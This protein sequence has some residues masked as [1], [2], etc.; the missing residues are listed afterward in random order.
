MNITGMPVQIQLFN[1]MEI[2]IVGLPNVGKSTLFNALT[3]AS[4]PA[5]NFPFTTIEPNVGIAAIEDER[6]FVVAKEYKSRKSTPAGIRFTDIA[7]LV[8]G[9]SAGEG[10]GNKFL[11]HIRAVDALAHVIRAFSDDN[12]ANVMGAV[13]PLACAKTIETE[14]LV[15]DLQQ[16]Q[17]ARE[18]TLKMAKAGDARLKE[19]ARKLEPIIEG[20]GKG[21]AVRSQKADIDVVR[22]VQ[23]LTAKPVMYVV[24][25]DEKGLPDEVLRPL[26]VS[27]RSEEAPIVTLCAKLEEE[28]QELPAEER[29]SYYE[30]AGIDV[31]GLV[32]LASA[33]KQ[34]LN[35]ICFYTANEQ[36]ARAWLIPQGTKAPQ[37]AGRIHSDMETGFIRAEVYNVEDLKQYGSSKILQ[38]KGLARTEGKDYV[39]REGDILFFRFQ[40]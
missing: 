19:K 37:A 13:D 5:E 10:L 30:E 6:L 1:K 31:P 38:E 17:N 20:L 39:V 15:A 34:L 26:K 40:K 23:F 27:V 11:S 28:I 7:G 16:A 14:L 35:L 8:R 3:G 29:S 22:D 36:E 32:R 33:G 18:R 24:N 21:I 25:C 2:G 12:V 9:A 4:V